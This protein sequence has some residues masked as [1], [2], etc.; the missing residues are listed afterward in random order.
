MRQRAM[1][2]SAIIA[3]L[4]VGT[5]AWLYGLDRTT[6]PDSHPAVEVQRSPQRAPSDPRTVPAERAPTTVSGPSVDAGDLGGFIDAL[7]EEAARHD[8]GAPPLP[9][10]VEDAILDEIGLDLGQKATTEHM[11]D[12]SLVSLYQHEGH[13]TLSGARIDLDNDGEW[14]ETWEVEGG[15]M[16]R[17]ISLDDDSTYTAAYLWTGETWLPAPTRSRSSAF[18][19]R[20]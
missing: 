1:L 17:Q 14:D 11:P 13:D 19:V 20:P 16:R 12:G 18:V 10:G 9:A 2:T 7:A 3:A 15:V 5:G 4:F 6:E 8:P